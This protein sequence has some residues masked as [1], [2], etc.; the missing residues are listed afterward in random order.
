LN[1]REANVSRGQRG[2]TLKKAANVEPGRLKKAGN[3]VANKNVYTIGGVLSAS[4]G[5]VGAALK[6]ATALSGGAVIITGL[7]MFTSLVTLA[8]H[9]KESCQYD[10]AY[11]PI[12]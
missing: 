10:I 5:V 11:T 8:G 7:A 4:S 12:V 2:E 3:Y 6:I 9:C 1:N